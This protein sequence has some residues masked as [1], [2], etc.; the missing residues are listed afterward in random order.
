[1]GGTGHIEVEP[2]VRF[3][4]KQVRKSGIFKHRR[5]AEQIVLVLH[6]VLEGHIALI[7]QGRR[8]DSTAVKI[9]G[10]IVKFQCGIA[11]VRKPVGQGLGKVV[12][13]IVEGIAP[14]T[15]QKRAGV[16]AELGI[17]G[18]NTAI[19][20]GVEV[21]EIHAFLHQA[22]DGRGV[23]PDG[24]VIHGFHQHKNHVLSRQLAGHGVVHVFRAALK[25]L[26]NSL[27]GMLPAVGVPGH[28]R[29]QL[30]FQ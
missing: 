20:G 2:Q 6:I 28:P 22:T 26:V 30:V 19:A 8:K 12:G 17:E 11:C 5:V 10:I 7:A 23:L 14:G 27:P 18:P 29:K 15:G 24:P 13:H 3:P 9:R 21:R 1:M 16:H 25:I 4:E